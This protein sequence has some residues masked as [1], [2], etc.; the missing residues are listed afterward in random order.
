MSVGSSIFTGWPCGG[1][2][3]GLLTLLFLAGIG[4]AVP[5]R[6]MYGGRGKGLRPPRR[7]VFG[8]GGFQSAGS[9]L[10]RRDTGLQGAG[11][12]R[13]SADSSPGCSHLLLLFQ[14]CGAAPG[15]GAVASPPLPLPVAN[16]KGPSY[17]SKFVSAFFFS[18]AAELGCT[19]D[20][21]QRILRIFPWTS[22]PCRSAGDIF[23]EVYLADLAGTP[24]WH[25]CAEPSTWRA[26][27]RGRVAPWRVGKVDRGRASWV[28][29]YTGN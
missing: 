17:R 7:H 21:A 9:I 24:G 11:Q 6:V 1:S 15:A 2:G 28:L 14:V 22:G 13:G 4:R 23:A 29:R 26:W 18:E 16:N 8:T 10:K 19:R 20:S 5:V 12:N 3:W 25:P 27:R